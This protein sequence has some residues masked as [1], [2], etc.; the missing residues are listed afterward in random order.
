MT[1]PPVRD[2]L[3]LYNVPKVTCAAFYWDA[4]Y[5]AGVTFTIVRMPITNIKTATW[6]RLN[7]KYTGWAKKVG[8][9]LMTIIL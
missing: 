7:G 5:K 6:P 2:L 3:P 4:V 8:H 9:R 1:S